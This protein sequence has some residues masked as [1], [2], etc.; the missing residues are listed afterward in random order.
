M[1]V[2]AY[3]VPKFSLR[4]TFYWV[5][6]YFCDA[7]NYKDVREVVNPS[8]DQNLEEVA[9]R[10]Q[11]DPATFKLVGRRLRHVWPLFP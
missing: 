4:W 1:L 10:H 6:A 3:M 5:T 2:Y 9:L 7:P 8:K 11:I